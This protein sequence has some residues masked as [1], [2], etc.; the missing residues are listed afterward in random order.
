MG[1]RLVNYLPLGHLYMLTSCQNGKY[2][3]VLVFVKNDITFA[4]HLLKWAFDLLAVCQNGCFTCQ[5][6][7]KASIRLANCWSKIRSEWVETC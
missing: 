7:V 1:T 3:C 2:T 6:F 4:N 5:M